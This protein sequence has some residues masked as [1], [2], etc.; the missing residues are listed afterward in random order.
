MGEVATGGLPRTLGVC[1]RWS[2]RGLSV[3]VVVLLLA[4]FVGEGFPLSV[5]HGRVLSLFLCLPVG[6]VLGT[7]LGW[8]F[9]AIGGGTAVGSIVCFYALQWSSPPRGFWFLLLALPGALF[10][11]AALLDPFSPSRRR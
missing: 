5:L 2:A 9:E 10:L 3:L 6:L 11:L 1:A 4:I 7:L 8:R